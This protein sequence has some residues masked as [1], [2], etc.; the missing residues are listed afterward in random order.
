MADEHGPFRV[1]MAEDNPSDVYFLRQALERQHVAYDL[2]VV[3]D[4]EAAIAYVSAA[5]PERPRPDL[6]LLDLNLPRY[7]GKEVLLRIRQRPELADVPVVIL[8]SSEFSG[9]REESRQMGASGYLTKPF[10]L[11]E[12]I[13]VGAK[14]KQMLQRRAARRD[15]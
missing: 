4:G 7:D 10:G 2:D 8:T 11:E 3:E 9:D 14:L 13:K 15:G 5:G 1:L 12:L 6:I